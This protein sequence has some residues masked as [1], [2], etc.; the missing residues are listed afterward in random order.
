MILALS[1]CC[2]LALLSGERSRLAWRGG[3][4]EGRIPGG[5]EVVV[6]FPPRRVVV[7]GGRKLGR[8]SLPQPLCYR[9]WGRRD[10]G[11]NQ[12]ITHTSNKTS[13]VGVNCVV[14]GLLASS[15]ERCG[16]SGVKLP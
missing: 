8:P 10:R 2:G 6:G 14:L 13:L 1:E 11:R 4:P 12:Y 5:E 9:S 7:Q 15:E 3:G 16:A